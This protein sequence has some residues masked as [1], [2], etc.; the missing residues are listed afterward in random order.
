M[1][2]DGLNDTE[3]TDDVFCFILWYLDVGDAQHVTVTLF[4]YCLTR[5]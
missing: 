5:Q 3:L 2:T 4:W 1:M